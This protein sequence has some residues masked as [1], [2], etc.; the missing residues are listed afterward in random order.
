MPVSRFKELFSQMCHGALANGHW[1]NLMQSPHGPGL[2]NHLADLCHVAVDTVISW[3]T[4]G[5]IPSDPIV[6]SL[7]GEFGVEYGV[8][9]SNGWRHF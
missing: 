4:K 7:L 5:R 2:Y 1:T 3:K 9:P 8:C 6:V